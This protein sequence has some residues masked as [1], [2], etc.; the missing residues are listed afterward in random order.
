MTVSDERDIK[1]LDP[2]IYIFIYTNINIY[3]Q[4]YIHIEKYAMCEGIYMKDNRDL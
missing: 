3:V 1:S 2:P 4:V